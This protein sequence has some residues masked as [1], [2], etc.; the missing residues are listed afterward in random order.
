MENKTEE[1]RTKTG[2]LYINKSGNEFYM[3]DYNQIKEFGT[4][5]IGKT[6]GTKN[7]L[8]ADII[9]N[10]NTTKEIGSFVRWF[11]EMFHT[12]A[13]KVSYQDF[14]NWSNNKLGGKYVRLRVH[15]QNEQTKK[16]LTQTRKVKVADI[17]KDENGKIKYN[18]PVPFGFKILKI[19]VI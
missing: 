16:I 3:G 15:Y 18:V 13:E 11:R 2:M 5:L 9:E 4:R 14:I 6:K 8:E 7:D 17:K 12:K 19:E 10:F 1:K